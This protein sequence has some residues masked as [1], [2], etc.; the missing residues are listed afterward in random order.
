MNENENFKEKMKEY[1]NDRNRL[2]N[3]IEKIINDSRTLFFSRQ[4]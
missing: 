4:S 2:L 3:N 1:N